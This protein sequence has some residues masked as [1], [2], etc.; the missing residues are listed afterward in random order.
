MTLF[1]SL[2]FFFF[3]QIRLINQGGVTTSLVLP[4]SANLFGG[5]AFPLKHF[6]PRAEGEKRQV[7]V[8]D[9]RVKNARRHLKMGMHFS[10]CFF[11][12]L[13]LASSAVFFFSSFCLKRFVCFLGFFFLGFFF[14][15]FVWVAC[16]ENP[17]R[18]YGNQG[19]TPASRMGNAWLVRDK[20]FAAAQL[21]RAQDDWCASATSYMAGKTAEA[22][23]QVYPEDLSL[24]STA[25]ILRGEVS[26][27]VHCYE[28]REKNLRAF[29]FLLLVNPVFRFF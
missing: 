1:V 27:Q 10:A 2:F 16:G 4:G 12:L 29:F 11:F 23:S 20:Y 25:A 17:K 13:F 21:V 9:L 22:P 24:E 28:V 6:S 5:E 18:S 3:L 14:C 7:T 26:L 15:L 19:K 8:E